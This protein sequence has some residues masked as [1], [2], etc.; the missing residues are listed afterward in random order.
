MENRVE[1]AVE[2]FGKG[3]NCSQAV[4][5][6]FADKFGIDNETALR[7]SIGFG[8]GFGRLREVCGAFSGCT[9]LI[10]LADGTN[11]EDA[12][13]AKKE[14]YK[15]VREIKEEFEKRNECSFICRDLLGMQGPSESHIPAERN[16]VYKATRPCEEIVRN[17]AIIMDEY[18]K[19]K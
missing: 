17:A 10:G 6:A 14:V 11:L 8:G 1:K 4:F 2:L 5:C 16:A 9:L 12:A 18:L 15:K 3:Y 7:L 13:E 19:E